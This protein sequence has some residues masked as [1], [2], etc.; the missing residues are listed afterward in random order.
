V[1]LAREGEIARASSE[2]RLAIG[3]DP[4]DPRPYFALA[5]QYEQAGELEQ[6]VAV[7][8]RLET[9]R[10]Q[11]PHLECRVAQLLFLQGRAERA[12]VRAETA[13]EREPA[14]AVAQAVHGMA[15]EDAGEPA[16][17]IAALEKAH[18]LAPKDARI[19]LTLAQVQGRAGRWEEAARL[20]GEVLA[21]DPR[22]ADA[23]YLRGWLRS[24]AP[25]GI[26]A[27]AAKQELERA[28]ALDP[29]HFRAHA[30]LGGLLARAGR[31]GEARTHLERARPHMPEDPDLLR[32]LARAY[33][34][35]GDP[36]AAALERQ[37]AGQAQLQSRFRE[38]RRRLRAHP[39]DAAAQL[40]LAR[41][42][43]RRGDPSAALDR[44]RAL[45]RDDPN[46]AEA[47][48]LMHELL[49]SP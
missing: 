3:L 40:E 30:A 4:S 28:L 41:L 38:L 35:L 7:L 18:R 42:E 8:E 29:E 45:L 2:W 9:A 36:R 21:A 34:G 15:L 44:V 49:R 31:F 43:R 13:A 22:S 33:R 14:C 24:R 12:L 39:G 25:G 32:D 17:A 27:G 19:A 1:R 37:A 46:N 10:P 48:Q 11:A 47:L 23:H 5:E 6:A 16:A 26:A 20:A